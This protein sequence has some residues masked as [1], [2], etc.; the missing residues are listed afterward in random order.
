MARRISLPSSV[1]FILNRLY[2]NGFEGYVVGGCVRDSL[3]GFEPHDWD[4]CTSALPEQ[5][6][7][8]FADCKVIPT[9]LQHG[10]ISVVVDSIPYEITTY[11]IDGEYKDNRHP[12]EVEFV[13]DLRLDLMRRDFTINAMA[14]SPQNGL[15]DLFGGEED[16]CNRTIRCV[17]NPNERFQEDALRILRAIR[18]AMR[19]GFK[20]DK[21]TLES[22]YLHRHLLKNI[23]VE[24]VCS[25]ITKTLS[26][27]QINKSDSDLLIAISYCLDVID[28]RIFFFEDELIETVPNLALR[29]AL[30][31]NNPDI[32][33]I[34]EKLRFPNDVIAQAIEIRKFGYEILDDIEQFSNEDNF[35][36][37]YHPRKL[38]HEMQK[39]DAWLAIEFA[40]SHIHTEWQYTA[41]KELSNKIKWCV[42]NKDVY[43]LSSLAVNGN[44]LIKIGCKGKQIGFILNELL[45]MVMNDTIKNTQED[46][47][48]Q[49]HTLKTKYSP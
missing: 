11:R 40:K 39:A 32:Q 18:F 41:L 35:S 34:M 31:F 43:K 4:I 1:C 33:D 48:L 46:L 37:F 3:M 38:L 23:S 30:I 15:V 25:E 14:F 7:D 26:S 22:L 36:I 13:S 20:I 44:D 17:G 45:D 10:T 12:D 28:E 5:M 6:M 47:L 2:S 21:P 16:I 42:E 8:I 29:L 49:A 24:R 9:G 19:Y 27:T